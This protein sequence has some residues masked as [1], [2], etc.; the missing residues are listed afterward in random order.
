M[1][2]FFAN[3]ASEG[4]KEQ[5]YFSCHEKTQSPLAATFVKL[6]LP[7]WPLASSQPETGAGERSK[8]SGAPA[9]PPAGFCLKLAV[10]TNRR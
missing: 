2:D 8:S 9:P 1:S 7:P 3:F 6:A 4:G 5:V 10:K